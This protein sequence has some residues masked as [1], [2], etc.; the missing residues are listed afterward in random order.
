MSS[1]VP[2]KGGVGDLLNSTPYVSQVDDAVGAVEGGIGGGR[3][4]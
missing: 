3:G 2:A 4:T 1:D